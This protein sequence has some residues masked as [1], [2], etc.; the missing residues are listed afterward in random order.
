M[1]KPQG[2]LVLRD[3]AQGDLAHL[4]QRGG[5]RLDAIS[6]VY[7]RGDLTLVHYMAAEEARALIESAGFRCDYCCYEKRAVRNRRL[8]K[9]MVS[10]W[11][12]HLPPAARTPAPLRPPPCPLLCQ[13]MVLTDVAGATL[14]S[15]LLLQ[16]RR[17]L[18]GS[19]TKA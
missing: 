10:S 13:P 17:W 18:L 19:F 4:R 11:S 16:H 6:S 2:R 9:T 5:T 14:S 1:L 3:Y 8:G 7:C 12:A 15:C